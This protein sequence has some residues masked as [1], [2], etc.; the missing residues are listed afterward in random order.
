[1]KASI[2]QMLLFPEW[3]LGNPNAP[4]KMNDLFAYERGEYLVSGGQ[5]LI[6]NL[7]S[8]KR[9]LPRCNLA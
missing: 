5:V 8:H 4:V 2:I 1:M 3:I 9:S 6:S 7:R